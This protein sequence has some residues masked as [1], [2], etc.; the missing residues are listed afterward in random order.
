MN[1]AKIKKWLETTPTVSISDLELATN[2]TSFPST[3][4]E[5][6]ESKEVE[7]HLEYVE[8][9]AKRIIH[10]LE[11]IKM[12]IKAQ[13]IGISIRDLV[14]KI[15]DLFPGIRIQ[16]LFIEHKDSIY[17]ITDLSV[18]SDGKAFLQME[19]VDDDQV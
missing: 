13:E 4:G 17:A 9:K 6:R 14:S 7:M 18:N 16:H 19:L 10:L 15:Q 1:E 2:I 5:L 3:P 8:T 12:D 11:Q